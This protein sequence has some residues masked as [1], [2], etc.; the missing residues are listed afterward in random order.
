VQLFPQDPQFRLSFA[1]LISKP[2][3][4]AFSV[5]QFTHPES[6]LLMLHCP[7]VQLGVP[8]FA[9]HGVVHP[10]QVAVLLPVFVSHPSRLTFS[11]ALQSL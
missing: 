1:L 6:Q 5:L 7:P 2:S 9:L 10:P 3:R 8:W 4:L 11:F